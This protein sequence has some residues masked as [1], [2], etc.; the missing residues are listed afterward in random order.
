MP[1]ILN[2]LLY[3]L[4]GIGLVMVFFFVYT[5]ITSYD[6]V[7][8]IR[9]GNEAAALSLGGTL[10][11]FS[12]TIASA[13]MNTK[14]YTE[15]LIWAGIAMVIQVLVFGIVT[16]LLKM[17]REQMEANNR[18]FGGLLGAIS[19]SIGLINAGGIS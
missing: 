17:S 1:A 3:L 2:Y 5:T 4:S 7:L 9:Q 10:I 12:L 14:N 8:M 16:R 18:A 11:G 6:E 19:I 13:M 15:F